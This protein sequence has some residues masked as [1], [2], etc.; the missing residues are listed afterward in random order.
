MN[1]SYMFLCSK[2][3]ALL[4]CGFNKLSKYL[5]FGIDLLKFYYSQESIIRYFELIE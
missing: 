4:Y 5:K 1:T 3:T 2:S